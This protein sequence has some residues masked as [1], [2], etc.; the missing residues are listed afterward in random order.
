MSVGA[1]GVSSCP[2]ASLRAVTLDRP[3]SARC[4]LSARAAAGPP[5][6]ATFQIFW[7]HI[8][9]RRGR[10]VIPT[11]IPPACDTRPPRQC[12]LF[13]PHESYRWAAR[14]SHFPDLLACCLWAPQTRGGA[15]ENGAL[16]GQ[17]TSCSCPSIPG[18]LLDADRAKMSRVRAL[19]ACV[20]SWKSDKNGV[21]NRSESQQERRC[22]NGPASPAVG[23]QA[24]SSQ[25]R[26][27]KGCSVVGKRARTRRSPLPTTGC[28]KVTQSGA[29]GV[30]GTNIDRNVLTV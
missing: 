4:V 30:D 11:S 3:V 6:A 9:G 27:S 8:R 20:N 5:G 15:N 22:S 13:V 29:K 10:L 19:S 21:A 14:C 12:P 24:Q 25:S 2:Q 1:K 7:H 28:S 23:E 26:R 17:E 16:G 18:H